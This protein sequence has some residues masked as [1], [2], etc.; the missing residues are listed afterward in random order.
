MAFGMEQ[1]RQAVKK[2]LLNFSTRIKKLEEGVLSLEYRVTKLEG[3]E[4]SSVHL[5]TANTG[6]KQSR[7]YVFA[8]LL[9]LL[10]LLLFL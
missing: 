3:G 2:S 7:F 6:I 5:E 9:L 4:T 1:K 8:L 10:L